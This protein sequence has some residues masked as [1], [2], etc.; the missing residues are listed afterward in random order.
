MNRWI[1]GL[2]YQTQYDYIFPVE[3][4]SLREIGASVT[5]IFGPPEAQHNKLQL[6]VS[7]ETVAALNLADDETKDMLR[8]NDFGLVRFRGGDIKGKAMFIAGQAIDIVVNR[9]PN[10]VENQKRA[11]LELHIYVRNGMQ[12]NLP[13]ANPFTEPDVTVTEKFDFTAALMSLTTQALESSKN[14]SPTMHTPPA[15]GTFGRV[16]GKRQ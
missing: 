16:F 5:R 10:S 1:L 2:N 7:A 15:Q 13:S 8:E 12:R 6:F 9:F 3:L 14:L 11:L 4:Y